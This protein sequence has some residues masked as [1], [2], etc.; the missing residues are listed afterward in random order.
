MT[1]KQPRFR[2]LGLCFLIAVIIFVTSV[3]SNLSVQMYTIANQQKTPFVALGISFLTI[4][5][6]TILLWLAFRGIPQLRTAM[7]RMFG[8]DET[9]EKKEDKPQKNQK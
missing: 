2:I 5:T 4:F 9:D 3:F 1:A 8:M 6:M 7:L